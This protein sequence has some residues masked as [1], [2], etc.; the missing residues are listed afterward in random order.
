M[1]EA[2]DFHIYHIA[3][4][5]PLFGVVWVVEF[6]CAVE[7]EEATGTHCAAA[8]D[9]ARENVC[10]VCTTF[11]DFGEG[12]IHIAHAAFTHLDAIDPTLHG[13]VIAI[14]YVTGF[15]LNF[16]GF[17]LIGCYEPGA[18]HGAKILSFGWAEVEEHFFHLESTSTHVVHDHVPRDVLVGVF[19][20]HVSTAF[21]DDDGCFEFKIQFV[22]MI[23]HTRNFAG[24]LDG[25]VV[26]EIEDGVLI[27]FWDHGHAAV[28]AGCGH[29][30]A[31]SVTISARSGLRYGCQKDIV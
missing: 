4:L 1:T 13:E 10:A 21:S 31:E 18:N 5:Q 23:G 16:V 26:G 20:F 30:L 9:I 29:V 24:A 11:Y 14:A 17:E 25:V 19:G 22:E 7:F 28:S 8:D 27:K 15:C 6:A 2:I 3:G 12:P